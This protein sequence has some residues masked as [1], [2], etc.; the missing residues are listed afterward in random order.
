MIQKHTASD[1]PRPHPPTS[2]LPTPPHLTP[3][4]TPA[5]RATAKTA[6]AA[7]VATIPPPPLQKAASSNHPY[8]DHPPRHR[9]SFNHSYYPIIR[10]RLSWPDPLPLLSPLKVK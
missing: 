2:A 5:P 8:S 7:A 6:R 1:R 3:L 4:P 9:A 10:N